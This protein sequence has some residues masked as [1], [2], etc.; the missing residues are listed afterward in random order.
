MDATANHTMPVAISARHVHLTAQNINLLFGS[1]HPLH[2]RRAL[3]QP[4]EFSTEET[5]TLI[6]P[7]GSIPHVRVVGPAREEDQVEISRTDEMTLG[8]DAPVRVSG[9]L[10]ETPGIK[11]VGP[12]GQITL[13]HGV[14]L[15]QRHVHMS[16]EDA[17]RLGVKDRQIVQ[18][19]IRSP[20]RSLIFG[21][22]VV[23]VSAHYKLELHLD[24][25]EGN[26]AGVQPGH[27]ATLLVPS[28]YP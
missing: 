13:S 9:D 10:D 20:R 15:T 6:G 19:L 22:V 16:P 18:V 23:R 11:L 12:A 25:D 24:T 3:S 26:A 8:L 27:R 21:D 5:I 1:G 17:Q 28:A 14:V 2:T 7:K 4:G